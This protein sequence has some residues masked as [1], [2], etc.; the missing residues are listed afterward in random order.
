M[1]SVNVNGKKI[2]WFIK[3]KQILKLQHCA[4]LSLKIFIDVHKYEIYTFYGKIFTCPA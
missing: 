4:S 1:R 3:Y 2:K